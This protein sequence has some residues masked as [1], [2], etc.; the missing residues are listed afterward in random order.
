MFSRKLSAEQYIQSYTGDGHNSKT[1]FRE[2][3][4][5]DLTTK[6]FPHKYFGML[7]M[8][9]PCLPCTTSTDLLD[10]PQYI[11]HLAILSGGDEGLLEIIDAYR[12]DGLRS[13]IFQFL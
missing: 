10:G 13:L 1:F 6:V 8:K 12:Q 4:L 3:Y 9:P 5:G 2:C 11:T 7:W